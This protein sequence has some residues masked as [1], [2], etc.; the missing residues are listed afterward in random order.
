MPRRYCV[1]Y[2]Y[3]IDFDFVIF[4]GFVSSKKIV[5][6]EIMNEGKKLKELLIQ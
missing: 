3:F 4:M 5:S 2:E 1:F 6:G